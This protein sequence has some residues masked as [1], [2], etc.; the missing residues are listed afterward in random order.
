MDAVGKVF[1]WLGRKGVLYLALVAAIAASTFILPWAKQ[2]VV[3]RTPIQVRQRVLAD[4]A[5]TIAAERQA[6]IAAFRKNALALHRTSVSRLDEQRRTLRA[7]RDDL[8]KRVVAGKPAWALAI[9]DQNE[10]IAIERAKLRIK[11]IDQQLGAISTARAAVVSKGASLTAEA[12]VAAQKR[13]VATL[14]PLCNRADAKVSSFEHSWRWKLRRWWDSAEHKALVAYRDKQC[15]AAR[16]AIAK[17][18]R[19]LQVARNK[20]DAARRAQTAFVVAADAV[21]G[22]QQAGVEL[23]FDAERARVELSGSLPERLRAWSEQ[24]QLPWLLRTAAIALAFIIVT[25]FLIRLFCFFVL[26]PL[27]IRRA[28]IRLRMPDGRGVAIAPAAPSATSV[29]VRLNPGE[30]LLVR[31]DYLQ[32]SSHAGAKG[33]QWFLDWTKPVTSLATGLTFLTRIRGDGEV[34]TVSAVRDGLAEVTTLT[35]PEGASCVL[36]PRALAAVAQPIRR[37][38][39]ITRH[40]RLGS[41]NA[42][43]TLQLRYLVFHGPAR[44]VL[45][46]GRGVRVERAEQGRVFGQDQLVGFSADLAYAVTRT[47]TFWPYFFGREQLLKDRVMAGEGVL[48]VEEAP[49]TVRRGEVRRGIEG[50]IDAGMKVFGM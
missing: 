27:A 17:R 29:A 23:A 25:P 5:S 46:G 36:Q 20:A 12:D 18:N 48:I 50:M 9:V 34:T 1:G 37:R 39:R 26:A 47:E 22:I 41:L 42:W 13:R 2:F 11:V 28:A 4:A 7:E 43:L 15:G 35:L 49:L 16:E 30:E 40:W 10:L 6:A 19:G 45:K 21:G 24:W 3:G 33:T 38:L 8:A 44:L 14:I 31:Q 32:T